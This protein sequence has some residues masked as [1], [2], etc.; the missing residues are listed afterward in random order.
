MSTPTTTDD[1]TL[2]SPGEPRLADIAGRLDRIASQI[3]SLPGA[4]IRATMSIES[5]IQECAADIRR[6][7]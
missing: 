1:L 5:A 6:M 4:D 3:A 7:I 2:S